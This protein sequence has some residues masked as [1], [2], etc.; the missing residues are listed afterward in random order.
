[1]SVTLEGMYW[2]E[3]RVWMGDAKAS[4]LKGRGLFEFKRFVDHGTCVE[5]QTENTLIQGIP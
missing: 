5:F 4:G 2:M 1:M 3:R